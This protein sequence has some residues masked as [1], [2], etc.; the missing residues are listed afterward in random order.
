[1]A[2]LWDDVKDAFDRLSGGESADNDD[3]ETQPPMQVGESDEPEREDMR[4]VECVKL[5]RRL[6][7]LEEPPFPG[8]LGQRIYENVSAYGYEMWEEHQTL[9][10]NHYGLNLADPQARAVLMQEM[11]AFLFEDQVEVPEDW[12]PE[13]EAPSGTAPVPGPQGKGGGPP[14]PQAKGGGPPGPQAKGGG[15]PGPQRK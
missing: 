1:M 3:S 13:E 5:G 2:P 15:P 7:G 12:I 14:G 9:I 11:E 6:P 4:M 8:E 10:I